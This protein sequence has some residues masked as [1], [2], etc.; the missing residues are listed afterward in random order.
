MIRNLL[1]L[2]AAIAAKWFPMQAQTAQTASQAS[3]IYEFTV[4]TIDGKT[5]SLRE[6]EGNVVLIVNVASRCGL[7]PQ[8][9]GL[10]ELYDTHHPDGLVILGF[11]A[12]DFLGQEPGSNADIQQFCSLNYGVSFP[13]FSKISVKGRDMH[14]LYKYL[15]QTTGTTPQW[16]FHKYLVDRQGRV[17]KSFSPQTLVDSGEFQAALKSLL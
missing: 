5:R 3:S 12:N 4:E 10:Q 13:M 9:A 7:T 6:Y 11:P 16:N 8:Y 1:M 14:P 2:P 17:V 15:S